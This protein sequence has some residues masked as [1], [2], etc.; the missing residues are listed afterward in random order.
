MFVPSWISEKLVGPGE[1]AKS[2]ISLQLSRYYG[3][4]EQLSLRWVI[5]P[6]VHEV[7]SRLNSSL[8]GEKYA[9]ARGLQ[10]IGD[11]IGLDISKLKSKGEIEKPEKIGE[12]IRAAIKQTLEEIDGK[13]RTSQA[14]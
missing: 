12:L 6:G 10:Q 3:S 14:E 13:I 11:R 5:T 9:L 2:L 4:K 7:R 8:R 1:R